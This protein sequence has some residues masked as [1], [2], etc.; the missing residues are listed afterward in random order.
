PPR[1][2]RVRQPEGPAHHALPAVLGRGPRRG[3][4]PRLPRPRPL[5]LLRLPR[6]LNLVAVGHN[7]AS[8]ESSLA[9][10]QV[11]PRCWRLWAPPFSLPHSAPTYRFRADWRGVAPCHAAGWPSPEAPQGDAG[12]RR[13]AGGRARPGEHSGGAHG[14]HRAA[15]GHGARR[16]AEGLIL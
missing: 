14:V 2:P 12:P 6:A 1:L 7:G 4:H 11:R 10:A 8:P 13:T 16:G 15:G 9:P 5:P 3:G